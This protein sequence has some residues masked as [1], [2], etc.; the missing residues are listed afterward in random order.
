MVT[1]IGTLPFTVW[2]VKADGVPVADEWVYQ[3][4]LLLF[5]APAGVA[6]VG[7]FHSS[8]DPPVAPK[9]HFGWNHTFRARVPVWILMNGIAALSVLLPLVFGKSPHFMF[10]DIINWLLGFAVAIPAGEV[11]ARWSAGSTASVRNAVR[12]LSKQVLLVRDDEGEPMVS[13]LLSSRI[14]HLLRL[15]YSAHGSKRGSN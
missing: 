5:L 4:F 12:R 14:W 1:G 10:L 11:V 15:M 6:F 7:A 3:A 9:L 8:F 13:N 2:N